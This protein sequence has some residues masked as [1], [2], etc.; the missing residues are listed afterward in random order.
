[1]PSIPSQNGRRLIIYTLVC[2]KRGLGCVAIYG[3]SPDFLEKY[4]FAKTQ[5]S[6]FFGKVLF[7]EKSKVLIFWKNAIFGRGKSTNRTKNSSHAYLK[8]F[9]KMN[10]K[11]DVEMVY[12]TYFY[13]LAPRRH[14]TTN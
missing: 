12:L 14:S 11:M 13:E 1:M 4:F 10:E 7:F 3:E 5:K 8:S 6:S 9:F 2:L